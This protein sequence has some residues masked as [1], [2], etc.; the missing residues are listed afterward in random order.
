MSQWTLVQFANCELQSDY[1]ANQREEVNQRD[2][3]TYKQK[4]KNLAVF[5]LVDIGLLRHQRHDICLC[6][7]QTGSAAFS[8]PLWVFYWL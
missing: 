4:K 1:P 8:P 3:V 2:E 5:R 7:G 6:G